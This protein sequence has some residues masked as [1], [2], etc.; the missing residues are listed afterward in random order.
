VGHA[1]AE[2]SQ[3]SRLVYDAIATIIATNQASL[4]GLT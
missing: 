3:R 4:A 2:M 1:V